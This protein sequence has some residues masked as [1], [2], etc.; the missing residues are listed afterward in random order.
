MSDDSEERR[1]FSIESHR[2]VEIRARF[3]LD[4]SRGARPDAPRPAV[5]TEGLSPPPKLASLRT[6]WPDEFRDGA[7]CGLFLRFDDNREKGGYPRGFHRWPLER[8]NAW[9]AGFQLGLLR[10][11][12]EAA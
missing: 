10:L 5:I 4:K 11:T 7:R 1:L 9:F 8:R 6:F 2:L 3:G 12:R